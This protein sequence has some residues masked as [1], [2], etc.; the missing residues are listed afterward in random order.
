MSNCDDMNQENSKYKNLTTITKSLRIHLKN[1]NVSNVIYAGLSLGISSIIYITIRMILSREL[2][3]VDLGKYTLLFIIF[4][5][6]AQFSAIGIPSSVSKFTASEKEEKYQKGI[7]SFG[8]LL[9]LICSMFFTL[10]FYC[11]TPFI[12]KTLFSKSEDILLLRIVILSFPFLAIIKNVLGVINGHRRM[13]EFAIINILWNS[14]ILIST[15]FLIYC[16]NMGL[17]GTIFS[18]LIGSSIASIISI[19]FIK[20]ELSFTLFFLTYTKYAKR[21]FKVALAVFIGNLVSFLN[22]Q[23]SQFILAYYLTEF[24]IA[25]YSSATTIFQFLILVPSAFQLFTMPYISYLHREKNKDAIKK[26]IKIVSLITFGINLF[27]CLLLSIFGKFILSIL[28]TEKYESAYIPL[29][30]LLIGSIYYVPQ[31]SVGGTFLSIE[32]PFIATIINC[33]SIILILIL[34]VLLVPRLAINGAAISMDI[35]LL[36]ATIMYFALFKKYK[37]I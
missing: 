18:L 2:S 23:I 5:F 21:I 15:I 9:S 3:I 13:F 6:G 32:K 33:I 19:F 12:T 17:R 20:N 14:L 31:I 7:A 24:E 8:M 11:I 35:G 10:I 25:I 34:T 36:F 30:I 1:P 26:L 37:L 27:L 22:S 4:Q 28:F 29:L 16:F